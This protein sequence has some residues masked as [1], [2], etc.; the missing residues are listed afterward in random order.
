MRSSTSQISTAGLKASFCGCRSW[1]LHKSETGHAASLLGFPRAQQLPEQHQ[2][3]NVIGV[4]VGNEQRLAQDRLT[5]AM[6]N[7]GEQISIGVRDQIFHRLQ[8]SAE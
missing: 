3:P 1:E 8:I 5:T 2:L 4:V 7:A 6:R